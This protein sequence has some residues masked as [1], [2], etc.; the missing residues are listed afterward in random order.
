MLASETFKWHPLKMTP[1][2]DTVSRSL[3]GMYSQPMFKCRALC[4][5]WDI[6]H[7]LLLFMLIMLT[8]LLHIWTG[9]F[10]HNAL[11]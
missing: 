4:Q 7:H 3:R 6:Q 9:T 1:R 8:L 10:V 5:R 2:T 11:L